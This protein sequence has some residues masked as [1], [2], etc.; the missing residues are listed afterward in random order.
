MSA[1]DH[2]IRRLKKRIINQQAREDLL[3]ESLR[4][5]LRRAQQ[6]ADRLKAIK[7]ELSQAHDDLAVARANRQAAEVEAVAHSNRVASRVTDLEKK[8]KV[9]EGDLRAS[10]DLLAM[11]RTTLA[12]QSSK[13]KQLERALEEAKAG[14]IPTAVRAV[15]AIATRLGLSSTMQ[16]EELVRDIVAHVAKLQERAALA[17][18]RDTLP[19]R[20]A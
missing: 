4:D 8:L 6:R 18:N 1:M 7:T 17:E 13:I 9:A 20:N 11:Q 5:A 19:P 15:R 16:F 2:E 12:E 14:E 3:K 10:R